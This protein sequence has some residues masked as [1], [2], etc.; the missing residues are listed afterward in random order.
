MEDWACRD[1]TMARNR[2]SPKRNLFMVRI[3]F[4]KVKSKITYFLAST[5]SK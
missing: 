1:G 4:L 3:A 5:S 2:E